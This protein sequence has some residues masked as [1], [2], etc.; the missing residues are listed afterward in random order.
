M[1]SANLSSAEPS[2]RGVRF[3]EVKRP[4]VGF[5]EQLGMSEDVSS[6]FTLF[7]TSSVT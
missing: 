2:T 3:K 1:F 5:P 7:L 6:N 4:W